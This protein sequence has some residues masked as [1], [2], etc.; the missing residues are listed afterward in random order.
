MSVLDVLIGALVGALCWDFQN[1][2]CHD[3]AKHV[4]LHAHDRVHRALGMPTP[5]VVGRF[6][7]RGVG[8]ARGKR[9][10]VVRQNSMS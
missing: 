7:G 9:P 10:G 6:V 4:R 3:Y 8:A 1:I 5:L 2:Y